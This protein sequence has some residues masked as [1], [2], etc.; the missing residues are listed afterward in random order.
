MEAAVATGVAA[1]DA[2]LAWVL[3]GTVLAWAVEWECVA[4]EDSAPVDPAAS[5]DAVVG[6]A[7]LPEGKPVAQVKALAAAP[8]LEMDLAALLD[9]AG[10]EVLVEVFAGDVEMTAWVALV[11]IMP[12][13]PVV[14]QVVL[15]GS[16]KA[17]WVKAY[18]EHPV[19]KVPAAVA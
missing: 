5:V 12:E 1:A 17:E 4:A 2:V 8:W 10:L 18:A 11:A 6:W 15:P 19:Q 13:S 3:V 16:V 9:K 14:S 7:V